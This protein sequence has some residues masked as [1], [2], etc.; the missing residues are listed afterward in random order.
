MYLPKFQKSMFILHCDVL[1]LLSGW[2]FFL[3]FGFSAWKKTKLFWMSMYIDWFPDCECHLKVCYSAT[4][5][6]YTSIAYWAKNVILLQLLPKSKRAIKLHLLDKKFKKKFLQFI[7]SIWN[8][9]LILAQLCRGQL[10]PL[11]WNSVERNK[12]QIHLGS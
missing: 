10:Y 11:P 1:L 5:I 3:E 8:F 12:R 2:P 9:F 7:F 6:L 4:T